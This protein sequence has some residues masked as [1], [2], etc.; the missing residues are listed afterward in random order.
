MKDRETIERLYEEWVSPNLKAPEGIR[1]M[2]SALDELRETFDEELKPKI[3]IMCDLAFD[4]NS[5]EIKQA[6]VE[7]FSIS[8]RLFL[9]SMQKS[10]IQNENE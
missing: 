3:D 8:T 5:E 10:D 6:F 2:S 7:G 9:E 1:K 4:I